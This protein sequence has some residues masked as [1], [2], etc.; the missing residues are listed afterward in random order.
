L[1]T[2]HAE[3]KTLIEWS[4]LFGSPAL[5]S[6]PLAPVKGEL[7]AFIR[8]PVTRIPLEIHENQDGSLSALPPAETEM[9]S[10]ID[11][12][13][14][15][16][17]RLYKIDWP[18]LLQ[19][20]RRD[21]ELSGRLRTLSLNPPLWHLCAGASRPYFFSIL[22]SAE[23][24]REIASI[25]KSDSGGCLLLPTASDNMFVALMKEGVVFRVLDDFPSQP[26]C[27]LENRSTEVPR[28]PDL[29]NLELKSHLDQRFDTI[30]HEFGSLKE[31]NTAL[32]KD[33]A[34]SL[35]GIAARVEPKYFQWVFTIMGAGSIRGA[36]KLLGIPHSSLNAK[37]KQYAAKGGVYTTLFEMI[38]A[39]R[40]SGIKSVEQFTEEFAEH[41]PEDFSDP[42]HISDLLNGLE[43]LNADNWPGV[44]DEL[45]ELVKEEL[46]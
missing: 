18:E 14:I 23:E 9:E 45:I 11:G 26:G 33:L 1:A 37:L 44:R 27:F 40:G 29:T 46:L 19:T 30:G 5:N 8:C 24:V 34:Q 15:K 21:L 4:R 36:A 25:L 28:K 22:T 35:S 17:L 2:N 3:R 43:N 7:A 38:K 16:D 6:V 39:R 32:K 41:Q 20:L 31:E 12:L 10:R 13:T 42:N